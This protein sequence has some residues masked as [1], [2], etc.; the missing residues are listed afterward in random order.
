MEGAGVIHKIHSFLT[1]CVLSPVLHSDVCVIHEKSKFGLRESSLW[2]FEHLNVMKE[3]SWHLLLLEVKP[4]R[5]LGIE[6]ELPRLW[7][8]VG[9][10]VKVGFASA[11]K[12]AR[13][14]WSG[15]N[16]WKRPNFEFTLG[17]QLKLPQQRCRD[18][19]LVILNF[20]K[21]IP[22]SIPWFASLCSCLLIYLS[23]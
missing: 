6:L 2:A 21:Q 15:E 10:F 12:E 23:N 9:K 3:S 8:A 19:E 14:L 18:H 7:W 17:G 5:W 1:I 20:G 22:V 13:T 16:G 4:P 11:T